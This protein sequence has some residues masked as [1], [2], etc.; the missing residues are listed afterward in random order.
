MK[1]GEYK[2]LIH[3]L[4]LTKSSLG[5]V[6]IGFGFG[7]VEVDDDVCAFASQTVEKNGC[8]QRNDRLTT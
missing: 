3:L 5:L 6:E 7:L 1:K 8:S 4:V 2:I